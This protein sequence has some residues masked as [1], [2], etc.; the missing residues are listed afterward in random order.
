MDK[1]TVAR[2]KLECHSFHIYR[3]MYMFTQRLTEWSK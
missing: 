1:W 3:G 2:L